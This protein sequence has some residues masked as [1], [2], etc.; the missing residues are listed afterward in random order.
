[1]EDVGGRKGLPL[2]PRERK[3]KLGVKGVY[4]GGKWMRG[5]KHESDV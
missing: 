1:M 4:W 3:G 2:T 5:E